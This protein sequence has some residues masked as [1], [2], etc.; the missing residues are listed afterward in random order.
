MYIL[1]RGIEMYSE[2]F[3]SLLCQ[4]QKVSFIKKSITGS[5]AKHLHSH[6]F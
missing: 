3:K 5:N 2:T 4:I 1:T 6:T